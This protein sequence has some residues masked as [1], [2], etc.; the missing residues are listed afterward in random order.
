MPLVGGG[1]RAR[2]SASAV[3]VVLAVLRHWG[4]AATRFCGPAFV[5][6]SPTTIICSRPD[7]AS[8]MASTEACRPDCHVD[9]EFSDSGLCPALLPCACTLIRRVYHVE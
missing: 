2:H 3:L 5:H 1:T 4:C 9:R 7:L 8:A 6:S